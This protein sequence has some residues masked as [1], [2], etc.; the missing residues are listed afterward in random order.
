[1]P[2]TERWQSFLD[3]F[4]LEEDAFLGSLRRECEDRGIPIIRRE[5]EYFLKWLFSVRT[6]VRVLE[7]G[8]AVGYSAICMAGMLPEDGRLLTI[9]IR[10]EHAEEA[11]R[12]FERAGLSGR[13]RS[14]CGDAGLLAAGLTD[15]PFDFIFLDGPK[16][17]YA[18]LIPDLLPKLVDGG[19]LMADNI[20]QGRDTLESRFA[21]RRR[22]RTIHKRMREF[23]FAITHH[24]D[25]TTDILPIGDGVSVSVKKRK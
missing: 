10:P 9:E 7:I 3:A 6:P 5:T 13:I 14:L 16:A 24:E 1:M 18:G 21:V 22:D 8:T 12:N 19:I 11:Q 23:L 17:Q 20:L 4:L 2:L 25:L 15:P